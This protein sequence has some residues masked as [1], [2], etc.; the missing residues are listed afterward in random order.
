[1]YVLLFTVFRQF[2]G[3]T[4]LSLPR[5]PCDRFPYGLMSPADADAQGLQK[6]LLPPLLTS[7]F[8]RMAG[9]APASFHDLMD[10]DVES[11]GSSIGDVA[12]SHRPS[13]ECAMA[14][15]PGQPLVE[16]ESLQTHTPPDPHAGTL[17]LTREHS[18]ELRQWR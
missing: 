7:E 14:D 13:W 11:D 10:D 4:P 1:M 18:E 16:A 5:P 17:A 8:M 9:Y 12:P 15:A 2:F 6:M 3:G